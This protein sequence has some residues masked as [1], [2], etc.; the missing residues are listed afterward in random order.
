MILVKIIHSNKLKK[1]LKH[2]NFKIYNNN[3][4]GLGGAI[5]LGIEESNG[6]KICIM[7]ADFIR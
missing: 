6:S 7:M 4:K 3:K 1:F 5:N 2:K